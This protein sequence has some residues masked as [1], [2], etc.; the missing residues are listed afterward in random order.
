MIRHT[1]LALLLLSP[2]AFAQAPPGHPAPPPQETPAA[3]AP[4]PVA[5]DR[6]TSHALA[7]PGRTLAF[8]ATVS[9][10]RLLNPQGAPQ[11]EVVTT[12][13]VLKDAPQ[14][15]P[16]TFVF[17]GG[18]GASSA[19]LNLGALGPW[20]TD[21]NAVP[22]ARPTLLDNA[23]T[24]LDFTDLVFIDPPGTGFSR[25][26]ASGD[27]VR[28]RIWSVDGDIQTLATVIRRWLEG[29]GRLQSPKF[30]AGESYGGFRGPKLARALLEEQGVGVRGMVLVS[31]VLDFNGRDA[32]WSPFE[33]VGRLPSM[34]AAAMN[35]PG[36]AVLRDIEDYAATDYLL[37]LVRGERD[38]AAVER[39]TQRVAAATGLDPALVRRR[40]GRVDMGTF[41][42]DREPGRVGSPYDATVGATDPFPAAAN[43]N[44]PDP[45]LDGL[46]GP[47]TTAMLDLYAGRLDW[48]PEGAPARQYQLLNASIARE[49]DYGRG[50]N[51]PES[52]GALRQYLALDPAARVLVTHGLT[53]L[54]TPYFSTKLLLDQAP[55]SLGA[56]RLRLQVYPGGHM[57]YSRD[58]SRAALHG[59]AEQMVRASVAAARPAVV[60]P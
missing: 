6:T 29:A 12:A 56:D 31:P 11:V 40:A 2:V 54:V 19:W 35:A 1:A 37:D 55:A 23:E 8:D 51:R 25:I 13:F 36:R 39:I 4:R 42:R 20:R 57:F 21:F 7:L 32:A 52:F 53:D 49:W 60:A 14:P 58:G 16:V 10:M 45:I 41:L 3:E 59:D 48:K 50:N 15:R 28:R 33:H 18:P 47:I 34:A 9:T 26:V 24:W 44:S 46:R 17:N 43:D 38:P 30:L 5:S 27:D 22:S